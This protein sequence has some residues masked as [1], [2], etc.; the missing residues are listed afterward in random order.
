MLSCHI[1]LLF[2]V[3][4]LVAGSSLPSTK[5]FFDSD[6]PIGSL[7][8]HLSLGPNERG[9]KLLFPHPQCQA[10]FLDNSIIVHTDVSTLKKGKVSH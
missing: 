6:F 5:E 4:A 1:A 10:H 3:L 2:P 9:R 7:G 8:P